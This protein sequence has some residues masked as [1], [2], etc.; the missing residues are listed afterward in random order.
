MLRAFLYQR[1]IDIQSSARW[2]VSHVQSDLRGRPPAGQQA[3]HQTLCVVVVGVVVVGVVVG[4]G[5][6]CWLLVV[7]V[8][9]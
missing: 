1:R 8:G 4:V 7:G 9:G 5:V 6:G 3:S 2:P